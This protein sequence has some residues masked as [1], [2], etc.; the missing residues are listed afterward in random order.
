ME[1]IDTVP[2]SRGL[3]FRQPIETG[4]STLL[5]YGSVARATTRC[6]R[7][8]NWASRYSGFSAYVPELIGCGGHYARRPT[9]DDASRGLRTT[10]NI[11]GDVVTDEMATASSRVAELAFR[12]NAAQTERKRV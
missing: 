3:D 6:G 7:G 2:R 11:Y 4:A 1:A 8:R 10:M 9:K 5:V 12:A